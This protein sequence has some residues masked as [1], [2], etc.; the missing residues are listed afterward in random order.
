MSSISPIHD[1]SIKQLASYIQE[2]CGI[3]YTS[4]LS[5][6]AGKL[7]RRLQE[8]DLSYWGYS[9][10]LRHDQAEWEKLIELVTINETYFY[11]EEQQV[12]ELQRVVLP[13][14]Q[15]QGRRPVRI[16]C[17]ASSTGEEPYSLAMAVE[18]SGLFPPGSL[19]I[20][21]TDI[22]RK[23]LRIAERGW[24]PK[25]S[26]CFRRTTDEQLAR[27]FEPDGDGYAVR[28]H[29][30]RRVSFRSVNL[31]AAS[32]VESLGQ[33]DVIFCRNVLIYFDAE[34]T[35]GVISRFY[36]R[37]VPGGY[38]FLGHAESLAGLST[39]FTSIHA[40]ATFYY[41]K[42]GDQLWNSTGS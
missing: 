3:D 33:V 35:G 36:E 24:Y 6:L 11:R 32:E 29:I 4:N 1:A 31:T 14:L 28:E 7:S 25:H 20:I 16:W 26:L 22:N 34:T 2:R 18:D 30:K 5:A 12:E 38:L 8:L 23:V 40:G 17:A 42:G 37:L 9:E 15:R 21:G 27:Y 13:N 41:R 39:E 19:E 10:L